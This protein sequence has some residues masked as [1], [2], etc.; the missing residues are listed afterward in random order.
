MRASQQYAST[1]AGVGDGKQ[2]VLGDPFSWWLTVQPLRFWQV[3]FQPFAEQVQNMTEACSA[4]PTQ[5][6]SWKEKK[7]KFF[8]KEIEEGGFRHYFFDDSWGRLHSLSKGGMS[9]TRVFFKYE[10][11][12]VDSAQGR[13]NWIQC[14]IYPHGKIF[15]NTYQRLFGV[16]Y[17]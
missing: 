6:I 15:Q 4:G 5:E 13:P 9:C 7:E 1:A 2:A 8:R 14:N 3:D 16:C 12:S 11:C 10:C 17:G